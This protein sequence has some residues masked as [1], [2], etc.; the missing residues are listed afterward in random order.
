[1]SNRDDNYS[2]RFLELIT[3]AAEF[4]CVEGRTGNWGT[5]RTSATSVWAL[6]DCGL[7]ESH[8]EFIQYCLREL[9]ESD[10][11]VR[12]GDMTSFNAEVWDTSV[13]LIAIQK[14]APE[15][16]SYAAESIVKWLLAEGQGNNFKNEPWETLWALQALLECDVA[17][18]SEVSQR[19]K[20]C[21][22]WVLD[23]RNAEGLLISPHYMGFLL[24]VLN[25]V[26]HQ[27]ELSSEEAETY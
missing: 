21:I 5:T 26:T 4:L 27:F 1:M 13:A 18:Q 11:A 23:R 14:G 2:E 17:K 20:Q 19:V 7:V 8:G 12:N 22:S 15:Q 6:C 9:V 3:K 16:F 25:D 10:D 24:A